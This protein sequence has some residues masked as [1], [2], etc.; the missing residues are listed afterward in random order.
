VTQPEPDDLGI[1]EDLVTGEAVVLDLRPASFLTRGLALGLDYLVITFAAIAVFTSLGPVLAVSDEALSAAVSLV[2]VVAVIIGIPVLVETLTRGRSLGK[3]AMGM[4]VVRDDGGP[5]RMRQALIRGLL[6][7]FEIWLAQGSI[8][9]IASLSNRRGKRLGDMLA[10]TYVVRER[11]AAGA[12]TPPAIMPPHLAGWAAGA[13]LGRVP[14]RLAVAA[15]QFLAR[16]PKLH[17]SSRHSLGVSLAQQVA[18]YVAPMPPPG[19]HAEEFL[20]AVLAERRERDLR[21]LHAEAAARAAREARRHAASP[22]S[23]LGDSLVGEHR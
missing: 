22:L 15:R 7:F 2:G 10:G 1:T 8:A 18:P 6:G 17:P 19:T 5:I 9:I 13:D 3:Y 11:T 16:A 23:P 4:R 20:A 14:D 21:R 12:Y